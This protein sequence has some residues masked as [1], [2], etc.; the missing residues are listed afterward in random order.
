MAEK[1]GYMDSV[2]DT[3][4][5]GE[6]REFPLRDVNVRS[7]LTVASRANRKYGYTRYLITES[8]KLG[9]MVVMCDAED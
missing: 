8:K 1:S 3:L 6:R 7:W 4:K 2:L 9:I 5:A